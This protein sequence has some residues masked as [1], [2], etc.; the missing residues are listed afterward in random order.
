MNPFTARHYFYCSRDELEG[1][2]KL[3]DFGF[4]CSFAAEILTNG[5]LVPT[6]PVDMVCRELIPMQ[7]HPS[8]TCAIDYCV[9]CMRQVRL[10]SSL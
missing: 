1:K 5:D 7:V 8:R 4:A 3:A 9:A 6:L 2:V 10:L